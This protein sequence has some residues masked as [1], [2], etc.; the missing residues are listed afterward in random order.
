M[1]I[2]G[3]TPRNRVD[4]DLSRLVSASVDGQTPGTRVEY[5]SIQIVLPLVDGQTSGDQVDWDSS[6]L[7]RV[8]WELSQSIVPGVFCAKKFC[9]SQF[10]EHRN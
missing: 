3:R 5:E 10:W 9:V 6:Q 4:Y 7:T 8:V 2:D 1:T